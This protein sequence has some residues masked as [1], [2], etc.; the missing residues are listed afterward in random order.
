MGDC[1]RMTI[2][3]DQQTADS[4]RDLAFQESLTLGDMLSVL[5]DIAVQRPSY[6]DSCP[7]EL[8]RKYSN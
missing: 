1:Y 8:A 6:E 3:T 2:R 7:T 4:F 5:I